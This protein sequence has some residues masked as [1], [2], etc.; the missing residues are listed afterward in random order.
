MAPKKVAKKAPAKKVA[1]K[2]RKKAAAPE[3]PKTLEGKFELQLQSVGL[4]GALELA[5]KFEADYEVITTGFPGLNKLI[6]GDKIKHCGWPRFCHAEIYSEVEGVGKTTISLKI[7]V[8]WQRAGKRVGIVDIEPSI[9]PASSSLMNLS[10]SAGS[11]VHAL[12]PS[13]KRL[14]LA[15][16]I[17]SSISLTRKTDATG[18]K[19]SSL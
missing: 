6:G 7:G 4:S 14:S 10:V 11:F 17:A 1:A 15:I 16:W 13:P 18:P 2:G 3:A 19:N 12:A 8:A 9:I 5:D